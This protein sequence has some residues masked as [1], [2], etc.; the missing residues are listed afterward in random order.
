MNEVEEAHLLP[1]PLL[2]LLLDDGTSKQLGGGGE[3]QDVPEGGRT[4][5]RQL[6]VRTTAGKTEA[7][8]HTAARLRASLD[9]AR[10]RKAT[11]RS[12]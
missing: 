6:T 3:A 1:Q 4:E 9:S 7:A 11:A 5:R 2:E 12:L 10:P 8:G